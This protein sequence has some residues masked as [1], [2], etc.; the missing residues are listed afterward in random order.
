MP[1]FDI[2]KKKPMPNE[3]N[4]AAALDRLTAAVL[5]LT[6]PEPQPAKDCAT[7]E[8]VLKVEQVVLKAI[9]DAQKLSQEDEQRLDALLLR[10]NAQSL[11]LEALDRKV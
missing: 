9:A 6:P 1:R 10:I 7:K 8:D 11:K 4:L 2:F 5:K 3:K